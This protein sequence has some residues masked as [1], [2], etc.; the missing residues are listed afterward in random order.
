MNTE[1]L[2]AFFEEC[3]LSV[4]LSEQDGTQVGELERWT[5]C[6]VDMII[7]LNPFTA[8]EFEE[9]VKDF[10]VDELID[11]HRQ[12][13]SYKSNFSISV[14][15]KDFTDFHNY[16]KEILEKLKSIS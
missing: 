1:D 2:E 4:C 5:D 6:G 14:S 3:G 10:D 16:L 9:Y 12:D 7:T 15:L 13:P 11:L 8:E